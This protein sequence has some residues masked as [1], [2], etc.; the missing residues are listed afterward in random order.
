MQ[1]V[2]QAAL[3]R[4]AGE[5][6]AFV[7]AACGDDRELRREVQ[8]LVHA[9]EEAGRFL[10]L[11]SQ[12]QVPAEPRLAPG[13]CLG[14]Y[15]IQSVVGAGG[16]GEVYKAR[17]TRLN[18]S[19]AIK[20]ISDGFDQD[21]ERVARFTREAHF[22]A[23]LNHPLIAAV[24]AFEEV[25]GW[26]FLVMEFV[27]GQT[28]AA[29]LRAGPLALDEALVI[30]RQ[31]ADG[32][33]AAHEKGIV[34]RDLKPANIAITRDGQVKILD[35][36]LA[37]A[38]DPTRASGANTPLVTLTSIHAGR[39][40]GTASYMAP[41]QA[42]GRPADTRSDV[43][44]FGCVLYE[45][46]AGRRAFE[47][48]DVSDT[49]A[50][51]L[52]DE[53]DWVA[54]PD[55]LPLSLLL[56]LRHCLEKEPTRRLSDMR[57][58]GLQIEKA[59][60]E[61]STDVPRTPSEPRARTVRHA[62]P[63]GLILGVAVVAWVAGVVATRLTMGP[64]L[65]NRSAETVPRVLRTFVGV[66]PADQLRANGDVEDLTE[67]RPS[68]TA[69]VLSPDG[70]SIV[71][72]AVRGATQQLFRRDLDRL[73]AV[74]IA[75][76]EGGAS[77]FFSPD[78]RWVGF[79]ADH[80]WKKVP[81][82]GGTG[83]VAIRQMQGNFGATWGS[84]DTI[85]YA[86]ATGGLWQ[87]AVAGG[88]P[89][90]ITKLDES[91]NE[92]SH[93]LPHM[94]PGS[95]AVLFTVTQ[96]EFPKWE[97]T[98]IWVHSFRTGERRELVQGADA[99]YVS[100]GHLVYIHA[101]NLLAV[102]FDLR[103]L[104]VTGGP[105]NVIPLVMQAAYNPNVDNDSGAGQFDVS[106]SGTLAYVPGGMSPDLER[107]L[108]W[109]DR[110][111]MA[112]PLAAPTRAYYAPRLSPDGQRVLVWTSG[113]DRNVWIYDIRR[114][115]LMPV[116]T[117]GRNSYSQWTPDGQRVTFDSD[118]TT[119]HPHGIY[120]K[121][122]DGTGPAERLTASGTPGSWSPDGQTLA[123]SDDD[124]IW[125]ITLS[126]DR[127]PHP[128]LTVPARFDAWRPAFSPDGRFLAY[129]SDESGRREVYVQPYPGP[130]M[131][132]QVSIE[133]GEAPA[134]SR[135]GREL[136]YQVRGTGAAS[137]LVRYV[138]APV[139]LRPTFTAGMPRVLFQRPTPRTNLG[140]RYYDVGPDGRFLLVQDRERAPIKVTQMT[141]VQNW[142]EELKGLVPRK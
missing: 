42:K 64:R 48:E 3:D 105:V 23:A 44:A 19:V 2:L 70:R 65:E 122:A 27:E 51:V 119:D 11:D 33:Q 142:L 124:G 116:T 54:L 53:P 74:P 32:L 43:W 63:A 16:C 114:G 135:D 121:S 6:M 139:T 118:A 66:A 12:R 90:Q 115:T 40:M 100:T 34:H 137:S 87:V 110:S 112:Q 24:Y 111:G 38:L 58:A 141:L 67:G 85:V 89:R 106:A 47:G 46:L 138:A 9:Q 18:R 20:I 59:L 14:P 30:A 88:E 93:R 50:A 22:L 102:P 134:W 52:R 91:R 125:T 73:E 92:V 108:V 41:E 86:Q 94:L 120:W 75:G 60:R 68:R 39:I 101:G 96:N 103:R 109:V 126:G 36:G 104:E 71:F 15:E 4:P 61:P 62:M 84:N 117:E 77:P 55:S 37:K 113:R 80:T 107:S 45:M 7:A 127:R 57:A 49:L 56:L 69:M 128:F 26:R 72:S 31:V 8:S 131:R 79:R 29:R 78:G 28:L 5:R 83:A 97:E 76:T 133:G 132:Q 98:Q 25:N 21:P 1:R 99:R 95:E 123:F 136:F 140:V 35:F 17:D 130:G 10:D 82:T 81:L 13:S 129:Q